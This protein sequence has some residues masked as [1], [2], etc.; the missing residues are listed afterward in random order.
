MLHEFVR[1]PSLVLG[2][3]KPKQVLGRVAQIMWRRVLEKV[4]DVG[5]VDIDKLP[6]FYRPRDA[7]LGNTLMLLLV[8]VEKAS[9][10]S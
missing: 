3:Q 9:Q 4:S 5:S 8:F 1:V 2:V 10:V 7:L 6:G